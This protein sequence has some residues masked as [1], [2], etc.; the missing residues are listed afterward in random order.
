MNPVEG[1]PPGSCAACGCTDMQ[2]ERVHAI[3]AALAD[4]DL[5]RAMTLGL[6]ET[7]ACAA[8]APACTLRLQ[9]ARDARLRAL[10]A[11]DRHRARNARLARHA[12]ERD[13]R[14]AATQHASSLPPAAAAILARA[15][16]KAAGKA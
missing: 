14:R 7:G 16:A 5:D 8:C 11:R 1:R 13:A 9:Q 12:A 2:G 4:D 6:L 15:K 10:A 3:V